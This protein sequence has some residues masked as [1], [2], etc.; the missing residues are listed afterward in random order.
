MSTRPKWP[1]LDY[2]GL[3]GSRKSSW[4]KTKCFLSCYYFHHKFLIHR[5]VMSELNFKFLTFRPAAL[6]Y[7]VWR[8][9]FFWFWS[10]NLRKKDNVYVLILWYDHTDLLRTQQWVRPFQSPSFRPWTQISIPEISY[11]PLKI[12]CWQWLNYLQFWKC[13][14]RITSEY[15]RMINCSR[16]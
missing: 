5:I 10:Y 1:N 7:N 11:G 3:P 8:N 9:L 13:A 14:K 16:G 4:R 15:F 6:F 12:W 2:E